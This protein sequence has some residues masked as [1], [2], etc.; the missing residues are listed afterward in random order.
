M[1]RVP[2]HPYA[3]YQTSRDA[4]GQLWIDCQ[5][6]ACGDR[7]RRPCNNPARTNWWVYRYSQAHAHGLQPVYK[8]GVSRAR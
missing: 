7:S 2:N 4:A 8:Q 1:Q 3:L 6:T 5:C